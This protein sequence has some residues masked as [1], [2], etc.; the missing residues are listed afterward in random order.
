MWR[1]ASGEMDA[2]STETANDVRTFVRPGA[3]SAQ[4]LRVTTAFIFASSV[5]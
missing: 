1:A 5:D 3:P 4:P 2:L